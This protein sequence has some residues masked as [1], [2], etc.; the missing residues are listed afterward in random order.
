MTYPLF[1][2]CSFYFL[3]ERRNWLQPPRS[4]NQHA[5]THTHTYILTVAV[6]DVK[7]QLQ[8]VLGLMD[9]VPRLKHKDREHEDFQHVFTGGASST[10]LMFR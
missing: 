3:T 5:G 8:V 6:D 9:Q 10:S 2:P 7:Q 1:T 4:L